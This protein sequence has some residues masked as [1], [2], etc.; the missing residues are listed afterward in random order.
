VLSRRRVLEAEAEEL[1]RELW[2]RV[3]VGETYEGVVSSVRGYGAFV[4]LGGVD[5]LLHVS[6][7]SHGRVDNPA[8]LFAVGDRVTVTVKDIDRAERRIGLSLKALLDD[9]W[10]E[11][12]ALVQANQVLVGRVTRIARFGAFVE[13][14]PGVEGLVHISELGVERRVHNPRE[15]VREGEEVTVRV[16]EVDAEKRRVSLTMREEEDESWRDD[17]SLNSSPAAK[18]GGMGTLGD[19]LKDKLGK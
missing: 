13:V 17:P 2:E 19:L 18:G 3:E 6:E 9:P 1:A 12:S 7:M 11:V 15:V 14:A 16:L 4:D 5:G 10:D 8:D